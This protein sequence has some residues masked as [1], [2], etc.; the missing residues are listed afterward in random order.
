[1]ERSE[2]QK[3]ASISGGGM[4]R[5]ELSEK[6][7]RRRDSLRKLRDVNAGPSVYVTCNG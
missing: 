7:G 1:M 2:K 5:G 4:S 3:D 6:D